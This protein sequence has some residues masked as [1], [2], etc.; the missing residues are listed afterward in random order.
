M[1]I[2][3][4]PY[5][6]VRMYF[7]PDEFYGSQAIIAQLVEGMGAMPQP[8]SFELV[9]LPGMGKTTT[10][11]E[12]AHPEGAL[13]PN[14]GYHE[15]LSG[16]FRNGQYRFF[17]VHVQFRTMP[18]DMH[19]F[20]YLCDRFVDEWERRL[21]E[22]QLA[23]ALS[24]L[25]ERPRAPECTA[26]LQRACEKLNRLGVRPVL[27][28]DDFDLPFAQMDETETVRLRPFRRVVAFVIATEQRL[29]RVNAE[30]AGSPFFYD[31]GLIELTGLDPDDAGRLVR[32]SA[33]TAGYPFPEQD[34]ALVLEQV[35][36]HPAPLFR[37][38][39]AL[40]E[41]RQSLNLAPDVPL[42]DK[43]RDML[44]G[45]LETELEHPF[46][47]YW[48]R[49]DEKEQTAL[50]SLA[51][52]REQLTRTQLK[53]LDLLGK[54]KGLVE[55]DPDLEM[56]RF[57]SPLFARFVHDSTATSG[58][59]ISRILTGREYQLYQH[60]RDHADRSCTFEELHEEIWQR[61]VGESEEHKDQAKRRVQVAV[62]RL[63]SKLEKHTGE[64]VIS[65]RDRGY[66]LVPG[67]AT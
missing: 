14:T 39:T 16:P 8:R 58:V 4:N 46:W 49:L 55:Y 30:A 20:T 31:I 65:V 56:F 25:G 3:D 47:L 41:L 10:L 67:P 23:R 6:R 21:E 22:Q 43:E 32:E 42:S 61:S 33:E 5:S 60:L 17:P 64:S 50:A 48:N 24:E 26:W 40:W 34:C 15:Y 1:S 52:N 44:L 66:R 13:A 27:L 11:R 12:L 35:G 37:A 7:R 53:A 9:G 18:T 62:S 59:D 51:R 28:L 63:R 45:R 19:A 2:I 54:E 36:R 29:E 57:F 38:C